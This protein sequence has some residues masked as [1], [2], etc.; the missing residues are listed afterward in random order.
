MNSNQNLLAGAGKVD[1]LAQSGLGFTKGCNHVTT[2]VLIL[3]SSR[4]ML[5]GSTA[6][7]Y[8]PDKVA[9]SPE[10]PLLGLERATSGLE[11][12]FPLLESATPG[13]GKMNSGL[14][15]SLATLERATLGLER[16]TKPLERE[17]SAVGTAEKL[18]WVPSNE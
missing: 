9:P 12:P 8:A 10:R 4:E 13:L 2:L 11:R 17:T 7:S 1:Q 15:G 3:I 18:W 6:D 16:A 14:E 5:F